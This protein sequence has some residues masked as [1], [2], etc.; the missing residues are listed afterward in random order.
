[1]VGGNDLEGVEDEWRLHGLEEFACKLVTALRRPGTFELSDGPSAILT[2]YTANCRTMRAIIHGAGLTQRPPTTEYPSR[3]EG[4][5]TLLAE[6]SRLV[7]AVNIPP[8]A[9]LSAGFS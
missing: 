5:C 7:D 8:R 4:I 2:P 1:M 3:S 6:R 9:I